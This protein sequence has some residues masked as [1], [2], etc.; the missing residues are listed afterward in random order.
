MTDPAPNAKPKRRKG[1]KR[2]PKTK[3]GKIDPVKVAAL[4]GKLGATKSELA[5]ALNI[6]PQTL[7]NWQKESRKL[8]CAL[9]EGKAIKDRAVEASLFQRATGYKHKAVKIMVVD[10]EVKKIPYTE[11]YAPDTAAA[12]FWLKNRAGDKWRDRS[13]TSLSNP[14]GSAVVGT[15]VIAPTVVF[16]QP[17]KRALDAGDVFDLPPKLV[18]ND[19]AQARR[20]GGVDCK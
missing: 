8:F 5:A 19:Q 1:R 9:E 14:D 13:E 2:G 15:T 10:G 3:W 18:A 20:T 7:R 17:E 16:V 6:T 4:A 11:Q 12:V